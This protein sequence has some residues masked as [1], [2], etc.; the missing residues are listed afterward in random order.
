MPILPPRDLHD[1]GIHSSSATHFS[2]NSAEVLLST[3]EK[4]QTPLRA[5]ETWP[6]LPSPLLPS[7]AT[8]SPL[9]ACRSPGIACCPLVAVHLPHLSGL[10]GLPT[11]LSKQPPPCPLLFTLCPCPHSLS[12]LQYSLAYLSFVSLP[13]NRSSWRAGTLSHY[14]C[15]PVFGNIL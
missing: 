6:C 12:S 13:Q 4:I 9:P 7:T 14:C 2:C 15:L 5:S 8:T 10:T 3:E 11:A 1:P